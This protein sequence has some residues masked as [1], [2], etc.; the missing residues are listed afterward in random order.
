MD[1]DKIPKKKISRKKTKDIK[2]DNVITPLVKSLSG[3]LKTPF[4]EDE[5]A[6]YL[7]KKYS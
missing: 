4:D 2:G 5:Y 7:W 1:E 3:I 6:E